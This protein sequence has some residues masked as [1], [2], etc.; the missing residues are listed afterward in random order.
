MI[1]MSISINSTASDTE[2][3]GL[4]DEPV[5]YRSRYCTFNVWCYLLLLTCALFVVPVISGSTSFS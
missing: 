2:Q 4:M 1:G 3:V 5:Q